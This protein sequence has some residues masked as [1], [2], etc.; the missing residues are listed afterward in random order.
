M[1]RIL[2]ELSINDQDSLFEMANLVPK[3]TGLSV[4][5]WADHKGESRNKIDKVPRVKIGTNEYQVSVSISSVPELLARSKYIKQSE[6]KKIKE[7]MDY[8]AK[9]ADIFLKHYLDKDD[10][11]DD[12]DLV[13]ELRKRGF[14]K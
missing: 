8:V 9:N 5:I 10:S 4:E 7:A 1:N 12:T 6:M 13:E 2:N 11:F 3:R 14:Y